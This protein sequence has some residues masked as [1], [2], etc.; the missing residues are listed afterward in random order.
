[1]GLSSLLHHPIRIFILCFIFGGT[2]VLLNG[3]LTNL[4]G[5]QRDKQEIKLSVER[6]ESDLKRLDQKMKRAKDATYIE[7]QALDTLDMASDED[8][9]FVFSE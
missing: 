6:L 1:M 4:Y 3:A 9:V 5:L 7:R 2:S 8:L